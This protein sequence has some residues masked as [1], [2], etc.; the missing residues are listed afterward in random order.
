MLVFGFLYQFHC[1]LIVKVLILVSYIF[2]SMTGRGDWRSIMDGNTNNK[3]STCKFHRRFR[4]PEKFTNTEMLAHSE[5]ASCL[6]CLLS[7]SF[8]LAPPLKL[9]PSF[10]EFPECLI[11][12]LL[13]YAVAICTY[14]LYKYFSLQPASMT[15]HSLVSHGV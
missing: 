13:L 11:Y 15:D 6:N 14:M 8:S 7:P 9:I 1:D 3:Q 12:L 10:S 5:T 4:H 2:I